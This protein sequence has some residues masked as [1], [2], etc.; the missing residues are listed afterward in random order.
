MDSPRRSTGPG[1]HRRTAD[2]LGQQLSG[3]GRGH[4]PHGA[5]RAGL[6][7]TRSPGRPRAPP[8]SGKRGA[9]PPLKRTYRCA[10]HSL[11]GSFV[12]RSEAG[13]LHGPGIPRPPSDGGR[14]VLGTPSR[15]PNPKE[16]QEPSEIEEESG[17]EGDGEDTEDGQDWGSYED[18]GDAGGEQDTE[19]G[20][21]NGAAAPKP[22]LPRSQ[23]VTSPSLPQ[24]TQGPAPRRSA[25]ADHRPA[26][27]GAVDEQMYDPPKP[28]GIVPAEAPGN[29][30]SGEGKDRTEASSD[31]W[32]PGPFDAQLRLWGFCQVD[33]GQQNKSGAKGQ[34]FFVAIRGAMAAAGEN[35]AATALRADVRQQLALPKWSVMADAVRAGAEG[36][37]VRRDYR[38]PV[39]GS[40]DPERVDLTWPPFLE[41]ESNPGGEGLLPVVAQLLGRLILLINA[42][43]TPPFV[44]MHIQLPP[45]ATNR[46]GRWIAVHRRERTF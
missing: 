19:G 38:K 45:T 9:S 34:C 24:P 8:L 43:T 17:E 5:V 14:R 2:P 11:P 36:L 39:V 42:N 29:E 20:E 4:C 12:P 10:K 31:A 18:L 16:D 21:G 23:P 30:K 33:G 22:V 44:G 1:S 7:P 37:L 32:L 40:A 41:K 25:D 27:E 3:R 35:Y 13:G 28:T 46:L 26:Q 6:A 15:P